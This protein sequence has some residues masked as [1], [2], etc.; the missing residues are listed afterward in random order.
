M[1][2]ILGAHERRPD[3]EFEVVF[4][5]MGDFQTIDGRAFVGNTPVFTSIVGQTVQWDVM[6]MGSEHHTF[7][8]HGHRWVA[9]RHRRRHPDRRPGRDLPHPLEGGG[10]R[11]VALPLPRRG[12]HDGRHDRHLPGRAPMRRARA[13]RSPPSL[14][15]LAGPA[16]AARWTH[17]HGG[18]P[19]DP[20]A[21]PDPVRRLRPAALDVLAGDTVR[22]TNDSV[23]AHTVDGRRRLVDSGRLVGADLQP[24]F[25]AAGDVA[26]YCTLHPFMRGE[27]D[28]H[29]VLLAAADRAR[30]ARAPVR[31][32]RPL[33]AAAGHARWASRPTAA[34]ASRRPATP[35][36]TPTGPSA[37]RS[38]RDDR[39]LPRRGRRRGQPAVQLLVLDRKI[40]AAAGG[41]AA[42]SPSARA[43]PPPRTG[44]P[45]CCSCGCPST[46]AGGRWPARGSTA[47]R[48]R[49]S[50]CAWRTAFPARVV[51]T[52]RDGATALAVSRTLHVGPR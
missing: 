1:L 52:L 14:A 45:S 13:R 21:A 40:A 42:P 33:G 16:A 11:H 6:A 15:A 3:R 29:N 9:G 22:W 25:D 44:R 48:W 26:Y 31:P 5:P 35:P 12:P 23:R 36:C 2:S 32:A 37:R 47:T 27:V 19:A 34:R 50:R 38:A 39:H 30:R 46:S 41:T 18:R 28:V 10:P 49:A 43:S 8:V 7:H 20:A 51:L 17:M 4:A 24:R